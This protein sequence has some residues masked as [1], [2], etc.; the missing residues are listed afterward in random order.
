MECGR[1]GAFQ[2]LTVNYEATVSPEARTTEAACA[3]PR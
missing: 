1:A 2:G 3:R